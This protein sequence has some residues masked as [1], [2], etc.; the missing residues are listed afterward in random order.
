MLMLAT[1]AETARPSN[2]NFRPAERS[3]SVAQSGAKR[4][5]PKADSV[6]QR[7]PAAPPT[8]SILKALFFSSIPP[9]IFLALAMKN[10]EYP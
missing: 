10:L 4:C 5:D 7:K 9:P 6:N 2:Q 1:L 8:V 3:G